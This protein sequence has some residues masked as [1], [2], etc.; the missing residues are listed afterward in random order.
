VKEEPIQIE[1]DPPEE[2]P[3]SNVDDTCNIDGPSSVPE[4]TPNTS[5]SAGPYKTRYGRAIRRP[6]RYM[7]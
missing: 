5:L 2:D 3:W 6:I 1:I 7:D 4:P